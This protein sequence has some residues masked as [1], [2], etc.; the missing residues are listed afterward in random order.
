M[1]P[2][3]QTRLHRGNKPEER[4]NCFP[5]VIASIL[6]MDVEDVIQIQE[7]YDG[8]WM[9]TLLNWLSERNYQYCCADHY[10]CFHPE[11]HYQL[12][13]SDGRTPDDALIKEMCEIYKDQYYLVA[14]RSPRHPDINHIVIFQNGK[15]IHD[16]HPDRSG[17]L[18]HEI[19]SVIELL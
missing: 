5:S 8:D 7:H 18:T 15:M 2:Q 17:I 9:G 6:E 3:T 13:N 4:G 12:R 19:F 11:L 1:I 16:P 14:G 10:K